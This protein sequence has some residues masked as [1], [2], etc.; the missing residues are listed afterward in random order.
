MYQVNESSQRYKYKHVCVS[1]QRFLIFQSA[2]GD[3]YDDRSLRQC[4]CVCVPEPVVCC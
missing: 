4:V 1:L 2:R 3:E